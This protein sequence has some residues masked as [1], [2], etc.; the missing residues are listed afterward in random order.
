MGG[1]GSGARWDKKGTVE[2][3][4]CLDMRELHR[5]HAIKPENE[6][7]INYEWRGGAGNPGNLFG[8]D[9][10]QLWRLPAM[11]YLHGLRAKSG[12]NIF[13]GQNFRLSA[14]SWFDLSKL[15]GIG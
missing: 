7:T 9:L 1:Y 8:L 4:Q 10:L 14:L 2:S 13:W 6:M 3:H 12:E 5:A 11:A 15:P